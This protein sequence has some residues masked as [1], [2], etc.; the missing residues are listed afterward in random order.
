MG[1]GVDICYM[2]IM[3]QTFNIYYL[4][5]N[6][7]SSY[8][9]FSTGKLRKR[10]LIKLIQI[11]I[12]NN[13]WHQNLIPCQ[14]NIRMQKKDSD[15]VFLTERHHNFVAGPRVLHLQQQMSSGKQR[16]V[17]TFD[18]SL[19]LSQHIKKQRHYFANKGSSS[20]VYGFSSG[21]VWMWELDCEE[22]WVPKNWCFWT[23]VLEKTR[24]SRG[25]QGDL[26]SPFWRRSVLGI[27]WNEW[28]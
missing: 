13:W 12:T 26:T 27:L 19:W 9:H 6:L 16:A 28:C 22:S 18:D 4:T 23:L 2:A 15:T 20:Q 17:E 5:L 3:W 7:R 8:S 1:K 11:H 24:E 25:S 10:E 14:K 21:H